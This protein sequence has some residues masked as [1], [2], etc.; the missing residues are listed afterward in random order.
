MFVTQLTQEVH[1]LNMAGNQ[2]CHVKT[3]AEWLHLEV[4]RLRN[5]ARI[6]QRLLFSQMTKHCNVH[7]GHIHNGGTS[8][9]YQ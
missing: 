1:Q 8:F 4:D 2:G 3:T 5:S 6:L 9:L 7:C